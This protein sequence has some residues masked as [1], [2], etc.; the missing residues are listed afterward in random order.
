H[1]WVRTYVF[2]Q[3]YQPLLPPGTILT[4]VGYMNNS[5]TNPNVPDP[6]NWQ[7]AG[8]RSVA[9]MF[10]DLGERVHM[11]PEQFAE[12]VKRRV[13]KFG[14]TKNDYFIGCPLCLALVPTPGPK[15]AH[16]TDA[17]SGSAVGSQARTED[18]ASN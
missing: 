5:E 8:N 15:P 11:T 16:L 9:N 17:G 4:I 6:R 7:G 2:E 13:D 12:E 3:E 10:I 18:D 14:L 1:N